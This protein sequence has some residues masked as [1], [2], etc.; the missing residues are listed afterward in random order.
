MTI[1]R[2]EMS[3]G[4]RALER[5]KGYET[6]IKS[7]LW[8]YFVFALWIFGCFLAAFLNAHQIHLW[9]SFLVSVL[10]T[11]WFVLY[12]ETALRIRYRKD[13]H[14]IRILKDRF[15]PEISFDSNPT[16]PH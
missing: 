8:Y 10:V 5:I 2:E 6:G 11:F 12:K 15:G 14:L 13:L 7:R 1:S 9:L 16:L 4:R 3:A